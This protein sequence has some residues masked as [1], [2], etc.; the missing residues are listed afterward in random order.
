MRPVLQLN[1]GA[2]P[3]LTLS[4]LRLLSCLL[5]LP[6][7]QDR[8]RRARLLLAGLLLWLARKA[9]G[10]SSGM[11]SRLR[12]AELSDVRSLVSLFA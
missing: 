1:G 7:E 2:P 3:L 8:R 6:L 12:S 5:T 11:L 4:S 10:E 9:R